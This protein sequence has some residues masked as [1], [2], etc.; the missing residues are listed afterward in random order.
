M[1]R[2]VELEA[3]HIA[4]PNLESA[5]CTIAGLMRDE[6]WV[7]SFNRLHAF[8]LLFRSIFV[9]AGIEELLFCPSALF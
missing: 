1:E 7:F 9:G 8:T 4:R 3:I 5:H 6:A 2:T